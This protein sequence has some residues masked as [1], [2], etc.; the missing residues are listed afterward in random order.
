MS[1]KGANPVKKRPV[2]LLVSIVVVGW[3]AASIVLSPPVAKGGLPAH[4]PRQAEPPVAWLTAVAGTLGASAHGIGGRN[5]TA[6]SIDRTVDGANWSFESNQ[7]KAWLGWALNT[8]GD[9]N[10]DG[11]DDVIIGAHRYDTRYLNDGKAYVFYG[12]ASG[13]HTTP[14]WTAVGGW[15]QAK[16]GHSVARA[17]DVNG[18]G[19]DD[20]IIGV[21]SPTGADRFGWAYAYYGSATGLSASPDWTVVGEQAEAWFGRTV[22]SAGDVNGDGYDDV[23]VG[24][25]HWDNDQSEEG[26]AYLYLGSPTGLETTPAWITE[27]NQQGALYGRWCGTAGDVNGDGYADVAVG[28]HFYDGKYRDEGR[29]FVY[30]GSPTG[31]STTADW[32]ADGGQRAGWFGRAVATAGDVNADGYDDLLV[33]APKYDSTYLNSG[34]AFVFFGSATGLS[35]TPDWTTFA[36]QADAWYGRRLGTARDVNGDGYADVVIGAPNY[37]NGSLVDAGRTYV[38]YG[39]PSGLSLTADWIADF[40]QANAW[41]GRAVNTAGDV[42]GDGYADVL[43]GA[44]NYTDPMLD[45]GAAYAYYGSPTGLP[46]P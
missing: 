38:F 27:G 46:P 36:D 40:G 41:F 6:H 42:N 26:R 33:G 45:E 2:A 23:V 25:P 8:A 32:Y 30:Y 16:L 4:R 13:L 12:S 17:G 11:Y 39:S 43:I 37:D 34:A 31:P 10:G 21:P 14:D 19:Y 7:V 35:A 1:S 24:A 28:A 3:G 22:N 29:T 44:P 18:D 9:V 5:G 20:V 15:A